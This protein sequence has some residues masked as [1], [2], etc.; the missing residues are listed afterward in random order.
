VERALDL[1][2]LHKEWYMTDSDLANIRDL[3]R[4]RELIA[5]KF[6]DA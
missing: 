6:G 1:G 2:F 3:P 4:F 5:G